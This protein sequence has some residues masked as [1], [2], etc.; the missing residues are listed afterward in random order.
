[1]IKALESLLLIEVLIEIFE[2]EEVKVKEFSVTVILIPAK[3]GNG[4]VEEIALDERDNASRNSFF[5]ILKFITSS[6]FIYDF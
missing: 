5:E 4:V 3:E 1:M 2:S 6:F